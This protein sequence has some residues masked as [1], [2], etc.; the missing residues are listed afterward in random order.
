MEIGGVKTK[1]GIYVGY[2]TIVP[3][4]SRRASLIFIGVAETFGET[5]RQLEVYILDFDGD[6]YDQELEVEILHKIR[7]NQKFASEQDLVR[8]MR[9]DELQAREYFKNIKE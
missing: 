1:D 9:A 2:C 6:L 3:E 7:G 8:Q 5:R 4:Q